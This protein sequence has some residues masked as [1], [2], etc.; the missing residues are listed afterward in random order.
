[1][2]I[3]IKPGS[4]VIC[5]EGA[6]IGEKGKVTS[7]FRRYDEEDKTSRKVVSFENEWGKRVTTRLAWV[8]LL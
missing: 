3:T 1:M 6:E 4:Q 7:V 8:R 5:V 2:P